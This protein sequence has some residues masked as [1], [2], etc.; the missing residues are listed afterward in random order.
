VCFIEE[1][2]MMY[3]QKLAVAIKVNGKVLREHK[4]TVL[5]PF[6][7]EYS[8]LI[9]NL[10]T[11]RAIVKLN[12]DSK[13]MLSDGLVINAGETV[14]LE[15]SIVNSNLTEGNRF[16]FIE[17]T[18]NI[19]N[20]RGIG[21]ED[22]LVRLEFQFEKQPVYY[23]KQWHG[24]GYTGI[25]SMEIRASS[26]TTNLSAAVAQD[27]V[28]VGATCADFVQQSYNDAGITVPGSVSNQKFSTVSSFPLEDEKHVMVLKLLGETADN[29]IV[30]KPVTVKAKLKCSTCGRQN[31]ATANFCVACGTSLQ[32]VY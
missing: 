22:G 5:I 8:I 24:S 18:A 19:E 9:K 20:H 25:R 15:R 30:T 1:E 10:N 31:K 21:L 14:E 26:A 27:S 17:R 11:K 3:N 13:D 32:L 6:G 28:H 7:S 16:K 23:Q 4:D 29:K 12:I 2:I